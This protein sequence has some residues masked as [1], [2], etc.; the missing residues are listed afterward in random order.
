K[1]AFGL[2]LLA[3]ENEVEK[4]PRFCAKLRETF[5]VVGKESWINTKE[6][7]RNIFD[8]LVNEFASQ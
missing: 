8:S 2:F 1:S 4:E 6:E 3:L 7:Y 5:A